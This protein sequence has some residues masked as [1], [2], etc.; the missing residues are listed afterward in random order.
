MV[1]ATSTDAAVSPLSNTVYENFILPIIPALAI[2]ST[3]AT[4]I[5]WPPFKTMI[6]TLSEVDSKIDNFKEQGY[7]FA[8]KQ[9]K[10]K[11]EGL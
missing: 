10:Q 11:I 4:T 8:L 3:T 6:G 2:A 5:Q 1:P 9:N 7:F